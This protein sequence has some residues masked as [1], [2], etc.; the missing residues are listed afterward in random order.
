M[1][2]MK[3]ISPAN[4]HGFSVASVH[5]KQN[6]LDV[7]GCN[8]KRLSG[9]A[10]KTGTRNKWEGTKYWETQKYMQSQF[11]KPAGNRLNTFPT[12]VTM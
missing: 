9:K 12:M 5:E 10:K 8:P 3:C 11:Q 7:Q 1:L 4:A 2:S 6:L